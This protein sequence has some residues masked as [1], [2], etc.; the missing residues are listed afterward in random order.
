M[1][2]RLE[3]DFP[4]GYQK[5]KVM[6]VINKISED[7]EFSC[8]EDI[9]YD[10]LKK[11]FETFV[12]GAKVVEVYA[13]EVLDRIYVHVDENTDYTIRMWNMSGSG[14]EYSLYRDIS[15]GDGSSHGEEVGSDCYTI[16]K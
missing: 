2:A 8:W 14:I 9:Y 15:D 12:P 3:A 11:V 4:G 6:E 16:S 1:A 10:F 7:D 13:T 5:V